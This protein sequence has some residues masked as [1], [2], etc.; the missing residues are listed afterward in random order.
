MPVWMSEYGNDFERSGSHD[1]LASESIT[2][3]LLGILPAGN[4]STHPLAIHFAAIHAV[5]WAMSKPIPL[6]ALRSPSNFAV[7]LTLS[8]MASW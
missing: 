4:G 5:G 7:K 1:G 8:S 3:T 2:F 6:P